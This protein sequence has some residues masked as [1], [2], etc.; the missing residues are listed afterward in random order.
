MALPLR[1]KH[2]PKIDPDARP[3]VKTAN[4]PPNRRFPGHPR[5]RFRNG[6]P[7]DSALDNGILSCEDPQRLQAICAS[8]SWQRIDRFVRKWLRVQ[9]RPFE[10]R[11]RRAGFDYDI[12]ILQAEFSRTQVLDRPRTGRIFFEQVIRENLDLGRPDQVQLIFDRRITRRTPGRFRTRV[13]TEGVIPSLHIDY[14][15]SRIKQYHKEGRALRTETTINNTRDFEIGRRLHNLPALQEV[16]FRANRRLLDVQRLSHD[17]WMG[18]D[19]FTK[20]HCPQVVDG[21]RAPALRFGDP[22]VLALLGALLVFRLLPRG[23]SN[24]DLREH[25]APLLGMAPEEFSAGQM[26]YDLRRL[27]LHGL[28]GRVPGSHRYQLTD[29]GKTPRS[30]SVAPMHA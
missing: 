24:R 26:T 25:V 22:R 23:F 21:Q 27:R 14:K 1:A 7:R 17:C 13:L 19:A 8:L 4:S 5:G 6:C 30:S 28:I 2:R 10:S 3:T 15:H 20:V 12:S 29:F 16:G 9:P 11:D 18:E